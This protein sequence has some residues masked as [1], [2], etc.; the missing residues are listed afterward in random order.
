MNGFSVPMWRRKRL[1]GVCCGSSL[2]KTFIIGMLLLTGLCGEISAQTIP[3]APKPTLGKPASATPDRKSDIQALNRVLSLLKDDQ[4][5]AQLVADLERLRSTM[6]AQPD[7]AKDSSGKGN[8]NSGLVTAVTKAVKTVGE[9]APEALTAPLDEKVDQA[10]EQVQLQLDSGLEQGH[11]QRF[12]MVAAPGW[13]LALGVAFAVMAAPWV[14]RGR[15]RL[16]DAICSSG[17][18]I[19]ILRAI[20]TGALWR[21]LPLVGGAVVIGGWP[22]LTYMSDA[23][24]RVFLAFAI[25]V[26]VAGVIW[27]LAS[28]FLALLGPSRGWRR[29]G[30]AQRRLV[31]W[32]SGLGAA[33]AA[34]GILRSPFIWDTLSA[35]VADLASLML[36][37]CIGCFTIVFIVKY[38]LVV[39][40][41][42]IRI[43]KAP[44]EQ[45]KSSPLWRVTRILA[46]RWHILAVLFVLTHMVVRLLGGNVDF[47]ISSVLSLFVIIIGLMIA[48]SVDAWLANY[49]ERR[50]RYRL[51]VMGRISVRYLRLVRVFAQATVVPLIGFVCLNI[52]GLNL[53]SWLRSETAWAIARP[54]LSILAALAV[55]WM[56]WVA[57]DSFIENALSSFDRYGRTRAQSARTKTL[58]PL[59]RNVVFVGLCAIILIAVLANLGINVAP[60]LAG[61]GIVGLAIGFGSQQLVQDVITGL[62]ILFEGTIAVGD[63]IDTSD[64]AG[65]VEALTIRTVKIRDVDGALH[66]VPFS[67]IKALKN[68]SRDYGVYTVKVAV[69]YGSDLDQAMD[70][71]RSIGEELQTDP[72]FSWEILAPLEIWG[73]DQFSPEGVVIMGVI[74]TRP[75][76]QWSVGREFNLRLKKRFDAAG[77]AMAVPRFSLVTPPAQGSSDDKTPSIVQTPRQADVASR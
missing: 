29:V 35:T 71:M 46:K 14:R 48:L 73:V 1:R 6:A 43:L 75:L 28:A 41:L 77:I 61:A 52:W 15:A 56:L 50:Q 13:L 16:A 25:P 76:Q 38:R 31:P 33:A 9:K 36:D 5:R 45:A 18:T 27:Q 69:G 3:Q 42:M 12:L 47:I 59:V 19:G 58:L 2:I 23:W 37:L 64:R 30:Y 11:I 63:V 49:A 26:F 34:S 72:K 4:A 44:A 53:G 21:L 7:A 20:L 57:L 62:F 32:I 74:K 54:V 24:M 60:L 68:R 55:G 8:E 10:A 22:M 51:G 65:V 66:S 39:R 40:S 17:D 67:Q 70:I